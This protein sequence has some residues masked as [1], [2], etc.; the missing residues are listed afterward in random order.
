MQW[1]LTAQSTLAITARCSAVVLTVPCLLKSHCDTL[2]APLRYS[3]RPSGKAVSERNF[4]GPTVAFYT[5][6][7]TL[8]LVAAL[9][10][11]PSLA[12]RY[13]TSFD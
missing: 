8:A 9:L 1:D 12:V 10:D 11:S 13:C 2:S 5:H 7:A 6:G 3:I 4:R